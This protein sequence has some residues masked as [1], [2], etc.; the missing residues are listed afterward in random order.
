MRVAMASLVALGALCSVGCGSDDSDPGGSGGSSGSGGSGGSGID[1]LPAGFNE[2]LPGGDTICARGTPFRYFVRPGSVNRLVIEFR[3]GGACWNDLTCS[4]S[5]SLFQETADADAAV[6]SESVGIYQHSNPDNP[7][8]DWHHVYIPYCTG[9]VHW[10]NA[11]RTYGTGADAFTIHHKGAVNVRA[12][13]DWV[14]ENVPAPEKVFVTGCSAGAYGS[15]LWSSHI[16]QHYTASDVNQLADS[17]AGVITD[18]F[19]QESFPMWN[20]L[21]AYPTFIPGVDPNAFSELPQLYQAIGNYYTDMF[22]SQ[23]NTMYDDNQ[24][25]Y[26]K[27]MGGGDAY[28]WSTK[29]NASIDKIAASAPNF[30]S[31]TAPGFQHCILPYPNFYEMTSNGVRLIDWI[32]DV[33]A[34]KDVQNVSCEPNCGA[35]NPNP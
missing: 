7:F 12:V 21:E 17:G 32:N 27:A 16:R 35:P 3:G 24:H 20:A 33:V 10:G 30:R 22:L 6:L 18:T 25:F 2:M 14:Y 29:M 4:I 34:D 19:F 1:K 23:Y 28:E 11:D 26:Y 15:I 13:L 5:G 9:D 31:Y 8:K